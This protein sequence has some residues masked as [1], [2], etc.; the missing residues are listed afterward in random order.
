MSITSTGKPSCRY[1]ISYLYEMEFDKNVIPQPGSNEVETF[2][3]ITLDD[4][5][6]ALM[7]GEFVANRAMVWLAYLIRHGVVTQEN[8]PAFIDIC[9]R[10]Q[11]KHDLFIVE[12]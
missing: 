9:Q 11:R 7:E 6:V 3:L 2:T 12:G 10:M 8:E 5:K 1:I 4:V